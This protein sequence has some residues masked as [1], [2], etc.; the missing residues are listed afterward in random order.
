MLLLSALIT[1]AEIRC[2][3]NV[4]VEKWLQM[5]VT[6]CVLTVFK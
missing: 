1:G 5:T 4:V 2:T 3:I 6:G